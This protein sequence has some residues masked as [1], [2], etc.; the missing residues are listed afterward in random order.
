MNRRGFISALSAF[1]ATAVLDPERLLWRRGEK[2]ISIP[3]PT[4][5]VF[6][7]AVMPPMFQAGD[8]ITFAGYFAR[9]PKTRQITNRLQHFV[10]TEDYDGSSGIVGLKVLPP[11][12]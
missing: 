1:A 12:S 9:N 7:N 11:L 8:V 2:L 10:V 6:K 4:P 5:Y 3:K